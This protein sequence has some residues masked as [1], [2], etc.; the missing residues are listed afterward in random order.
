MMRSSDGAGVIPWCWGLSLL[1][2]NGNLCLLPC[3]VLTVLFLVLISAGEMQQC[4]LQL[5]VGLRRGA[6]KEGQRLRC[7]GEK[8]NSLASCQNC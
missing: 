3:R 2:M 7:W 8:G 4:E 6:A 5:L 1:L